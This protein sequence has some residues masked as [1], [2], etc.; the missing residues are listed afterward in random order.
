MSV[1][2]PPPWP[3]R[4]D[5]GCWNR[6]A[7]PYRPG[8]RVLHG[9]TAP[10]VG[11][12]TAAV[13]WFAL[14][15]EQIDQLG[16]RHLFRHRGKI[17]D[18]GKEDACAVKVIG[19]RPRFALQDGDDILRQNVKQQRLRSFPFASHEAESQITFTNEIVQDGE[20]KGRYADNV[21]AHQSRDPARIED[22]DGVSGVVR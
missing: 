17:D 3:R 1:T 18:V 20:R 8:S 12:A 16:R 6:R 13:D 21:Q 10:G 22:V 11:V 4:C 19:D 7:R 15:V 5:K 14:L 2:A 9:R